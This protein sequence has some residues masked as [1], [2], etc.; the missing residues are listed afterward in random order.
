MPV[1]SFLVALLAGM[2]VGSGGLFVVCL[3]LV[4]GMNQLAAQGL[5]LYFY[6]FAAA[7][8]LSL[9]VRT[10]PL[11]WKRLFFVCAFGTVGLSTGITPSLGLWA[12]LLSILLMYIGR[13]GPLTVATLWYFSHGERVRFPEGDL[14]IG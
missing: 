13:L 11:K 5:N 2:G 7:A 14:A 8:A 3:T 12:K 1:A 6:I 9:H 4:F 10:A